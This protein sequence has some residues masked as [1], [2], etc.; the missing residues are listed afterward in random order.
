MRTEIFVSVKNGCSMTP[1][2]YLSYVFKLLCLILLWFIVAS[3]FVDNDTNLSRKSAQECTNGG[4]SFILSPL[5]AGFFNASPI[6]L[7]IGGK[8]IYFFFS[9]H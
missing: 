3:N 6:Y 1:T 7:N 4:A 8:Y 9:I 5:P 2:N